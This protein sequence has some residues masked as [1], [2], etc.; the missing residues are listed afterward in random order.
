[1][2]W[3]KTEAARQRDAAVYDTPEYR[4]NRKLAM[5]RDQWRCQL[6]FTGCAGAASQCDHIIQPDQ[7]GGHGLANLRAVCKPCHAK[8]TA[9]QSNAH[10]GSRA[11]PQ[12]QPRTAW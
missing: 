11:D 7:G 8:R 10:S 3:K 1:M 9:Q 2:A 4:R 5:K 12:P 6:R